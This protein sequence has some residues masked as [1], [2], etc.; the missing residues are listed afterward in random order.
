MGIEARAVTSLFAFHSRRRWLD[1]DETYCSRHDRARQFIEDLCRE[2]HDLPTISASL[3]CTPALSDIKIS[4]CYGPRNR[5]GSYCSAEG[6]EI[7]VAL[8]RD[9][10][11]DSYFDVQLTTLPH[12]LRH[13]YQDVLGCEALLADPYISPHLENHILYDRI[14]E[15]DATAF[16]IA[17]M[18]E[19]MMLRGDDT[20]LRRARE[21][22][23]SSVDAYVDVVR[24][25]INAHW[26]GK[27]AHAAFEAYFWRDNRS[28][29]KNYDLKLCR[30]FL[31]RI[32]EG[33]AVVDMDAPHYVQ[34][35]LFDEALNPIVSMP[36]IS[37][38]GKSVERE[39]YRPDKCVSVMNHISYEV[40]NHIE[41]SKRILG[42]T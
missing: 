25:D 7:N 42:L 33:D 27:A 13:G 41:K 20:P 35:G 3:I 36:F 40:R 28:R 9:E 18:Y 11:A 19:Y 31:R 14:V 22:H 12:E 29:L 26:N 39:A 2:I 23:R 8:P 34:A 38:G 6:I 30:K 1:E 4:A 24:T 32:E 21:V 15:A 17:A 10:T 16:S 5:Y 37:R